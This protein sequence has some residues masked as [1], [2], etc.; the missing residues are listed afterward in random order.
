MDNHGRE[1][2][3]MS[4]FFAVQDW[5][6]EVVEEHQKSCD[7]SDEVKCDLYFR[8]KALE[9]AAKLREALRLLDGGMH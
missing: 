4:A 1:W 3:F 2:E 9:A 8:G 5:W 7:S 6:S